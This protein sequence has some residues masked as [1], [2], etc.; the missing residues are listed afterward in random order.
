MSDK[1]NIKEIDS[2]EN[3]DEFVDL[4]IDEL[5]RVYGIDLKNFHGYGL[6]EISV[7][8]AKNCG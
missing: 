4:L 3:F 8:M 7:K 5:S 6:P 2:A 1:K